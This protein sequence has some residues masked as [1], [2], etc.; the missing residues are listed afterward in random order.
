MAGM[1]RPASAPPPSEQEAWID[2]IPLDE[3]KSHPQNPKDHDLGAIIQSIE[4][5]G[6]VDPAVLDERTGYLL[7][8]H[9]RRD[10]LKAMRQE[11]RK[12]PGR[13]RP[14]PNGTWLMMTLRGYRSANDQDAAAYV[15]ADNRTTLLGGFHEEKLAAMLTSL[16]REKDGLLGT[17]Y[18]GDDVDALLE[19]LGQ[20]QPKATDDAPALPKKPVT[21]PGDLWILGDQRVW[22]GDSTREAEVRPLFKDR[23][24]A[25]CVF[26]DPPYGVAYDPRGYNGAPSKH[27]KVAGDAMRPDDLARTLLIP[28]LKAAASVAS[29]TAAWYVW[30]ASSTREAFA[31]ALKAAGLEEREYLIWVKPAAV[32]GYAD[33][34]WAHEPCFYAA[35]AGKSPRFHG[36]RT[37]TTVWRA[38]FRRSGGEQAVAVG[39][40][41]LL[42]DAAGGRLFVGPDA[43]RG[44]KVRT[45]RL[46]EAAGKNGAAAS[47]HVTSLGTTVWEIGREGK[48]A[49]PTQKPV[50]LAVRALRNSTLPGEA[51]FDPFLGSGTTLLAAEQEGRRCIGVEL[52]PGYCDVTVERWEKLSGLKA[53]REKP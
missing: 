22:C 18:D 29:P 8:G 52:D 51:V 17:G 40:G 19:R 37:H 46:E 14:G 48:S 50:E 12:L 15:L 42:V 24:R 43:P 4:R 1:K 35:Q 53:T 36:D 7:K 31:H 10:A 3:L 28:A 38:S 21:R 9:G 45:V 47:I 27:K 2:W 5:A 34:R 11:G 23:G 32:M 16:A 20:D 30:H 33:Y 49:H 25:A 39:F 44:R 41:L 13:V 6:F 26:T